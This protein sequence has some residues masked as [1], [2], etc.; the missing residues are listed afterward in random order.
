MNDKVY[1]YVE[2]DSM[3]R[4]AVQIVMR[5]LMGIENLH[6]FADSADFLSRVKA[7]PAR[8]D[9]F[10]LDIHVKPHNGF[11]MLQMLRQEPDYQGA[12]I[13]ALT[14]SVMND[15]VDLLKQSGFDGAIAKPIQ[16]TVFPGLI[17]GINNGESVWHITD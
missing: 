12:R 10:L 15:E 13:I 2:D 1:L 11:E 6:M 7:L 16:V 8:P 4:D 9:V 3:S 17:A 5:R 14:A